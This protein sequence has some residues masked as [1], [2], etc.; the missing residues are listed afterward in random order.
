MEPENQQVRTQVGPQEENSL[1]T[2]G[3]VT[4]QAPAFTLP[5]GNGGGQTANATATA[6]PAVTL[7]QDQLTAARSLN[8][9]LLGEAAAINALQAALGVTASGTFDDPTL[10]AIAGFQ[11]QAG[12]AQRDGRMNRDTLDRI[13]RALVTAN[14]HAGVAAIARDFFRLDERATPVPVAYN[15]ALASAAALNATGTL[16]F[17][18]TAFT[19]GLTSLGAAVDAALGAGSSVAD[20]SWG[21]LEATTATQRQNALWSN[22]NA[23]NQA[24]L[25]VWIRQRFPTE[26]SI[27]EYLSNA[28]IP[29]A[30]KVATLGLLAVELG[31]LEFLMG[32]IFHG[33]TD[34][35]WESG[36]ANRGPFV[37]RYKS[38][39]GNTPNDSPWCT[40]FSG[41][42]RRMLGFSSGL[43]SRGPLI[44]NSGLRFDRWATDNTNLISGR[45]DFDDPADYENYSG[46]SIDQDE[47]I[48]LRT[49]LNRRG[50]TQEQREQ[51]VA[52]FF[53]TRITPQAGDIMIINTGTTTNAYRNRTQSH[54]VNV[55]SYTGTTVSTIEGNRGDKVTGVELDLSDPADAGQVI[56]LARLGTEF[57]PTNPP[58]AEG[59][60]PA[61]ASTIT[62]D[63]LLQPLQS[64]TRELQMLADRRGYVSSNAVGASVATMAGENGGGDDL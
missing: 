45:D 38:T 57:F 5:G 54:T 10:R 55:E 21:V 26:A 52:T 32:V 3:G 60:E 11:T 1:E 34:Q 15:A 28:T 58:P 43:A 40:M 13:V 62:R 29:Q 42:L 2:G 27:R 47:W 23:A 46:G 51:E 53:S 64:M 17:G 59:A 16:E 30:D 4:R 20:Q 12:L 6:L 19:D 37:N 14:N 33:G 48:T 31:R 44:F 63:T 39:V 18:P 7:T 8:Q 35:T 9:F 24:G 50:I 25:A 56:V 41:Y 22:P 61:P 49:T 36:G